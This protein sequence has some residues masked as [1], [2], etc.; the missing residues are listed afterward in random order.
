MREHVNCRACGENLD[1]RDMLQLYQKAYFQSRINGENWCPFCLARNLSSDIHRRAIQ[2]AFTEEGYRCYNC[3]GNAGV[4][5]IYQLIASLGLGTGWEVRT[6]VANEPTLL[7]TLDDSG[8]IQL[9]HFTLDTL[10]EDEMV[11]YHIPGAMPATP[12]VGA[13]KS[14]PEGA[15]RCGCNNCERLRIYA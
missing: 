3:A 13:K 6:L 9:V 8:R 10:G 14:L 15:L 1:C 5:A 2:E 7:I 12:G 11:R 4:T